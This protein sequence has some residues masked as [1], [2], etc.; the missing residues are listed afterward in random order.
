MENVLLANHRRLFTVYWRWI[1]DA[2]L[3][4]MEDMTVTTAIGWPMRV[5]AKPSR[6]A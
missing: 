2:F 6:A 3:T 4:A 5:T 1:E